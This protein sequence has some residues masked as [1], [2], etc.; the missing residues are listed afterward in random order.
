M[1]SE[2]R[3]GGPAADR[4]S[5][6]NRDFYNIYSLFNTKL[7]IRKNK[8]TYTTG[9][10]RIFPSF[11]WHGKCDSR[12]GKPP[13]TKVLWLSHGTF[14]EIRDFGTSF[15]LKRVGA[16]KV[17]CESSP[18]SA[19]LELTAPFFYTTLKK[20]PAF[21][22]RFLRKTATLALLA[23]TALPTLSLLVR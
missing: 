11:S 19:G 21:A 4:G 20:R 1:I 14:H 12:G 10:L 5:I 6:H 13:R 9:A 2:N 18:A 3:A 17:R 7:R 22:D 16:P 8:N 15:Q 23:P